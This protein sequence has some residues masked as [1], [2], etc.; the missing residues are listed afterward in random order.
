MV[1]M[2]IDLEFQTKYILNSNVCMALWASKAQMKVFSILS[3]ILSTYCECKTFKPFI[4]FFVAETPN[5]YE[6]YRASLVRTDL[7]ELPIAP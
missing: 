4:P 2:A 3:K 7:H 6:N 5:F 1:S